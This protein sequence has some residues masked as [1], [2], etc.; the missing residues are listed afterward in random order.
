MIEFISS[1]IGKKYVMALSGIVW[2]GFVLG[3]MAGNLL[4]F[5]SHDLYNSYGHAITHG[6]IIYIAE[7]ILILSLLAHVFTAAILT[8]KNRVAKGTSYAVA[9]K[10]EKK[11]SWASRNMAAQGSI[12]LVFL[13]IHL[14]TF[15]FGTYYET[16]V[17][18]VLMRD[19]ARIMEEVF[20]K[21]G[22]VAWY[23]FCL[24][25][26]IFHLS[27]GVSSTFQSLG[28]INRGNESVFKKISLAYT[29]IVAG[30][31][32]SLPIFIFLKT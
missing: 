4:I 19:L 17:N 31:F 30:G 18:G 28:L 29:V 32:I 12:V 24:I 25:I 5:I 26:L 11:S 13:I 8:Y 10:G 27:H 21:S 1:S 9:S 3:H 2:A 16:T 23:V 22:Y 7:P 6:P 20:H 15:K 14:I